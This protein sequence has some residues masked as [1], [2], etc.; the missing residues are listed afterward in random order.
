M[1]ER[2]PIREEQLKVRIDV[3]QSCQSIKP[4]ALQNGSGF[5]LKLQESQVRMTHLRSP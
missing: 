3:P 1:R 4:V 2:R 5:E